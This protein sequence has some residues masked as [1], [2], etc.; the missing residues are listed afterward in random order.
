MKKISYC[1]VTHIVI[2]NN[3]SEISGPA[4]TI[5]YYL[6][7]NRQPFIFIRH[8]IY[9][10]GETFVTYFD[11]KNKH[12]ETFIRSKLFGE[13]GKRLWEGWITLKLLTGYSNIKSCTYIGVDPLNALWGLILKLLGKIKVIVVFTVDYAQTRYENT[14][15]NTIYHFLD[16]LTSSHS[17]LLLSVSNRILQLRRNQGIPESKLIWLPNSPTASRTKRYISKIVNPYNLIVVSTE[18][19]VQ[20]FIIVLNVV[21]SLSKS[22]PGV[23]L[24]IICLPIVEEKLKVV[25][26]KLGLQS[27]VAFLGTMSHDE[28]FETI[29]NHGIGIAFY[30][31][32]SLWEYY[33]D[34][35]KTRDYLALGLPVII[36][37]DNGTAEDIE[38]NNAGIRIKENEYDLEQ[39]VELLIT[40]RKLYNTLR[41][42]AL[43]LARKRDSEKILQKLF[44]F[45]KNRI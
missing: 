33:I 29:A 34:S 7:R 38:K 42:N 43:K 40:N 1:I 17:D 18:L 26:K 9:S 27:H 13:A 11:G 12:D 31:N 15:Y 22:F 8:S 21:K 36:S 37:G 2:N 28:L 6:E 5:S 19:S 3:K 20:T 35:M 25:V 24:S 4:H 39:A 14:L 10:E 23:K 44:H 45:S 30:A 41:T 16:K 32:N